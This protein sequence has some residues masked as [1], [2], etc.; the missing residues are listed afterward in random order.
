V[1]ISFNH[2]IVWSKDKEKSAAYM[3][4]VFGLSDATTFGTFMVVKLADGVT[5]AFH[6]ISG[7]KEIAS[8]HYAFLISEDEFDEIFARLGNTDQDYW[9]DP[10]MTR[11][12]QVTRKD[13]GRG[14]YFHDPDGHLL[15]VI[16]RPYGDDHEEQDA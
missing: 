10:A 7:G 5:M 12:R 11:L 6:D 1:S 8:Q 4:S 2:T 9:A 15:E 13:G 3:A 16:T 14:I